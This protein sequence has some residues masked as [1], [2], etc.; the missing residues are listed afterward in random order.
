VIQFAS[1]EKN[2]ACM[3]VIDLC[4]WMVRKKKRGKDMAGSFMLLEGI[5]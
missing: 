2:P 5:Q 1:D 3:P 4:V